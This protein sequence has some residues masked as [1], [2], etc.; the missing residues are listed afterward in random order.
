MGWSSGT[1]LVVSVA[2]AIRDNVPDNKTRKKLYAALVSAAEDHDWDCQCEATGIDPV[3]DKLL[4]F[5]E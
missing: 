3:L 4:G 5:E 2:T 1:D